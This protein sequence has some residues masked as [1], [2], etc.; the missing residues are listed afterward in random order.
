MSPTSYQTAP[1][2]T[3]I[4]VNDIDIVKLPTP[5]CR[6]RAQSAGADSDAGFHHWIRGSARL[7]LLIRRLYSSRKDRAPH[8]NARSRHRYCRRPFYLTENLRL[9]RSIGEYIRGQEGSLKS[10]RQRTRKRERAASP[11][12]ACRR[13]AKIRNRLAH[14]AFGSRGTGSPGNDGTTQPA[15]G[16]YH[17]PARSLQEIALA[18]GRT[19]FLSAPSLVR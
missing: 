11:P 4:I 10:T 18:G 1:P 5:R 13:N 15:V 19:N 9:L 3:S 8:P 14:A 7:G 16:R 6:D 2:R 12:P 17:D